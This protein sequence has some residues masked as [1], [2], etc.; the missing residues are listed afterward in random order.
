M[1]LEDGVKSRGTKKKE[2]IVNDNAR[3]SKKDLKFSDGWGETS[4]ASFDKALGIMKST[5]LDR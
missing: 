5:G 1:N 3:E 2:G 4:K